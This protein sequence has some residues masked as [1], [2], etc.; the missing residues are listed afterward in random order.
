MVK[1][2]VTAQ[3]REMLDHIIPDCDLDLMKDSNLEKRSV[4]YKI[5]R[6]AY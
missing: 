6:K 1:V 4:K 5:F 2:C 3:H